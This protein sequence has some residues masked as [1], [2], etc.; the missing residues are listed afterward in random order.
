MPLSR[1]LHRPA[2]TEVNS[3]PALPHRAPDRLDD[4]RHLQLLRT[5]LRGERVITTPPPRHALALHNADD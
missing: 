4:R 5:L 1:L 3:R 2:L